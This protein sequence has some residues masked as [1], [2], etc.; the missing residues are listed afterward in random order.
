MP[1]VNLL[2]KN[3][4]QSPI[5]IS[6]KTSHEAKNRDGSRYA[7]ILGQVLAPM[8]DQ[9]VTADGYRYSFTRQDLSAASSELGLELPK[10]LGDIL[11]AFRYRAKLPNPILALIPEGKEL[12]IEGE[13]RGRYCARLINRISIQAN[14]SIEP[15]MIEDSTPKLIGH[16]AATDEQ[17]L[18]AKIRYNRLIDIF[19][20]LCA[21]SVQNHY[22]TTVAGIGQ[23][24]I[25][26]VYVGLDGK[27]RKHIITVQAKSLGD[28]HNAVQTLQD[29]RCC[30]QKFPEMICRAVSVMPLEEG[31]IAMFEI[32]FHNQSLRVIRESHF[33]MS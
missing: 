10:N 6:D 1:E 22:R 14:M 11:Y 18:L 21:H 28:R 16:V 32:E 29:I 12:L 15:I 26:E 25:D 3:E 8:V 7:K 27:G 2:S 20:G 9:D 24:E 13:G 33:I 4:S 23:I 17:G 31:K 19:L 5:T 30:E